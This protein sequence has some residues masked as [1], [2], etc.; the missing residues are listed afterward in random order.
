MGAA[1]FGL[2]DWRKAL[3]LLSIVL[4]M[5]AFVY[6]TQDHFVAHIGNETRI[7]TR[8]GDPVMYWAGAAAIVLT[9]AACL[10]GSVFLQKR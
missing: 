10:V 8:A 9:A 7:I 3:P 1:M 5:I 2:V 4:S 6:L